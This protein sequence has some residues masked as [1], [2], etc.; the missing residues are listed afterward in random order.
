MKKR[1]LTP[2]PRG[3]RARAPRRCAACTR[4]ETPCATDTRGS[5]PAVPAWAPPAPACRQAARPRAGARAPPPPHATKP[6][7]A[8]P[9]PCAGEGLALP[10]VGPLA[11]VLAERLD[12]RGK[13]AALGARA[14]PEVNRHDDAGRRHVAQNR[15]EPLHGPIVEH[16]GLDPL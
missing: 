16:M 14:E 12:A 4:R 2:A 11:V 1:G 9:E 13:A 10:R 15:R 5:W 7:V 3:R 6:P 8:P